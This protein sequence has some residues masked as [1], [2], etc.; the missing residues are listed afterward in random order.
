LQTKDLPSD[1]ASLLDA[2]LASGCLDSAPTAGALSQEGG[3]GGDHLRRGCN[4]ETTG[5]A[6]EHGLTASWRQ[7]LADLRTQF[8]EG[9]CDLRHALVAIGPGVDVLDE[10]RVDLEDGPSFRRIGLP[11]D[12]LWRR[13]PGAMTPRP[14]IHQVDYWVDNQAVREIHTFYGHNGTEFER[15]TKLAGCVFNLLLNVEQSEYR[16]LTKHITMSSLTP[17]LQERYPMSAPGSQELHPREWW[18]HIVHRMAATRHSGSTL[19][20]SVA[21]DRESLRSV[22]F[23]HCRLPSLPP[24]QRENAMDFHF[25]ILEADAFTCSAQAIELIMSSVPGDTA[26]SD[27]PASSSGSGG[28]AGTTMPQGDQPVAAG[29]TSNDP[30]QKPRDAIDERKNRLSD[31]EERDTW[32]YEEYVTGTPLAEIVEQSKGKAKAFGWVPVYTTAAVTMAM[33]RAWRRWRIPKPSHGQKVNHRRVVGDST[34]T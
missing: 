27:G 21:V 22:K 9:A 12:V 16:Q 31:N 26:A 8:I 32:M 6:K 11:G 29:P 2:R 1:L 4:A 28:G 34:L 5:S 19:H 7:E 15:F 25:S 3:A 23:A 20:S 30:E 14:L 10:N 13:P 33:D 24:Q 17:Q 18:M